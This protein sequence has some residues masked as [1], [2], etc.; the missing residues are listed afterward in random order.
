MIDNLEDWVAKVQEK[1]GAVG[2]TVIMD[3]LA[4]RLFKA[5]T[6]VTQLL[7]LQR[8][9]G[10]DGMAYGPIAFGQGNELA[11]FVGSLGDLDFWVYNDRYVDDTNTVKKLLPDYTVIIGSVS[12]LEGVRCYGSIMDEKAGYRAQRYFSKS[13]LEEDPAVRW[14]LLQ[15]APLLVP[16]RP[17]AS[18][19]ATVR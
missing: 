7:D 14:L 1:S 4:W 5:D 16:Y 15:S 8:L 3:A 10:N 11:R 2:R 19:C 18:F 13:W 6:K 17:N 12:Q 9:R